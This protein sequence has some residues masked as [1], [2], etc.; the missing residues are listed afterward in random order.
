M[1]TIVCAWT[2]VMN[3]FQFKQSSMDPKTMVA[4]LNRKCGRWPQKAK[5]ELP[6]GLVHC[7]SDNV[8]D[9]QE[10]Q[11]KSWSAWQMKMED[12]Y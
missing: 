7:K 6:V 4:N 9:I 10:Q 2:M 1:V 3:I 12:F 5:Q 8:Q 11:Q